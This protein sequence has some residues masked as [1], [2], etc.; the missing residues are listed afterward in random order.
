MFEFRAHNSIFSD[1]RHCILLTSI[2]QL[3][4]S[5][6]PVAIPNRASESDANLI[7]SHLNPNRWRVQSLI[8]C[9]QLEFSYSSSQLKSLSLFLASTPSGQR[10][11]ERVACIMHDK[12]ALQGNL[13]VGDVGDPIDDR[14]VPVVEALSLTLDNHP[15]PVLPTLART[16]SH[17]SCGEAYRNTACS[18]I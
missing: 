8:P 18:S 3:M 7:P 16:I 17:G 14:P 15:L 10:D 2:S 5:N 4:L 6:A 11:V 13:D 1:S 12:R 9:I